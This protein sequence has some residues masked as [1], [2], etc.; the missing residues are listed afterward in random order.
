MDEIEF[1]Y[2]APAVELVGLFTED[3]EG[4]GAG[5]SDNLSGQY[6]KDWKN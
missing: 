6:H 2:E 5:G 1:E 3:T 4:W